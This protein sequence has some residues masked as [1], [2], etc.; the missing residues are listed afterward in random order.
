MQVLEAEA[1]L[2][3]ALRRLEKPEASALRRSAVFQEVQRYAELFDSARETLRATRF[4]KVW[5]KEDAEFYVSS[6]PGASWFEYKASGLG[7]VAMVLLIYLYILYIAFSRVK[8]MTYSFLFFR[9]A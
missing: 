3:R 9:E 2:G 7:P 6:P 8:F 1:V 4:K 5:Q